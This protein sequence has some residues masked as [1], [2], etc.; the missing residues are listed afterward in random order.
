MED[1][2]DQTEALVCS[3][4]FTTT[5]DHT[6]PSSSKISTSHSQEWQTLSYIIIFFMAMIAHEIALEAVSKS[7]PDLDT[8]AESITLFQFG[9]SFFLPFLISRH[10]VYQTFPR[11][12]KQVTP[13]VGLS[14]LVFGATYLATKSLKYVSFPTKVVFKSAKLIP[15]M[16]VS[17]V[18]HRGKS[19]QKY[20]GLD[21]IAAL[22]VCVGAAGYGYKSGSASDDM[23]RTSWY[24][25]FLL[26]ISI[27]CDALLP[28][29][30]EKLMMRSTTDSNGSKEN[31]KQQGL[32]AAAVMVNTNAVGF[33][34]LLIYM[35]LSGSLMTSI[36]TTLTDPYLV[37]YLLCVGLCLSTAV[38]AYTKLVKTQGSVVAVAIST[39]RKIV[40]VML[41]YVIFPKPLTRIHIF[42]GLL[43]LVGVGLSRFAQTNR[44]KQ[45]E[46]PK[47]TIMHKQSKKG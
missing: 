13:Y 41:S 37:L 36:A 42:S 45:Q 34:A 25:I 40:S 11:S 29:V 16:I 6:S 21:Y 14:I 19:N 35:I 10:T 38:L 26:T 20:G 27:V 46:N 17:A 3:S 4:H 18:V 9:F 47:T 23:N 24:G 30:Q 33:G 2:E 1:H 8:L 15:T 7:F 28:N 43:V 12:I 39:F 22:F 31:S 32:S 44:P 5:A